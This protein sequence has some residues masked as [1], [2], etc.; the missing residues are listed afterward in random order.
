[1]FGK[2]FRQN[3]NRFEKPSDTEDGSK[4]SN[5]WETLTKGPITT[6]EKNDD[7]V[8][9]S[10]EKVPTYEPTYISK[11]RKMAASTEKM[12]ENATLDGMLLRAPA[13]FLRVVD[14]KIGSGRSNELVVSMLD[15]QIKNEYLRRYDL[16]KDA[17]WEDVYDADVDAF[18]DDC[19][20]ANLDFKEGTDNYYEKHPE[21]YRK[22]LVRRYGLSEDTSLEVARKIMV[23]QDAIMN[24]RIEDGT[25]LNYLEK[26]L[27]K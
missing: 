17:T 19:L 22:V 24:A 20:D 6:V 5:P 13:E 4:T 3:N 26:Y 15:E 2:I 10:S 9:A 16:P 8:S 11:I 7:S 14:S 18:M 21:E 1:M 27:K 12:P 23:D 25:S